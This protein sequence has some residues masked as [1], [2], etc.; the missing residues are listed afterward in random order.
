[1]F[2]SAVAEFDNNRKYTFV[3]HHDGHCDDP[4]DSAKRDGIWLPWRVLWVLQYTKLSQKSRHIVVPIYKTAARVTSI[5]GPAAVYAL[6]WIF[7]HSD[8]TRF[9]PMDCRWSHKSY[10]LS[11]QANLFSF[12]PKKYNL[13]LSTLPGVRLWPPSTKKPRGRYKSQKRK[14]PKEK[15]T[16]R[17]RD[18]QTKRPKEKETNRQRDQQTKRPTDKETN[19]QRDQ[20]T[21]RPKDKET[22]RQRDQKTKRP[23]DKQTK[24]HRDQKT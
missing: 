4:T 7:K 19:R 24:R 12:R 13:T 15:E 2:F 23:N 8:D 10:W 17:E 16:N 3:F 1:M 5:L 6:E 14:R 11:T 21:K 18:Q 20:Q 22:K 9:F